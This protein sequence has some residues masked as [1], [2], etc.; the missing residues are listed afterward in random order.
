VVVGVGHA[1]IQFSSEQWAGG[2]GILTV[3][4]IHVA[5]R[6]FAAK[7]AVAIEVEVVLVL[8]QLSSLLVVLPS[9]GLLTLWS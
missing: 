4:G 5:A 1:S 7:A 8:M 6:W 2:D 3:V 9:R